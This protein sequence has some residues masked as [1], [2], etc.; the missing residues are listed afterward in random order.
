MSFETSEYE[1]AAILADPDTMAAIA[2]ADAEMNRPR[3][4]T[5]TAST[6]LSIGVRVAEGPDHL[7]V[8]ALYREDIL[9]LALSLDESSALRAALKDEEREAKRRGVT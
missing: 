2:E 5:P 3:N 7:G 4:T 1:T 6:L 8:V 9:I